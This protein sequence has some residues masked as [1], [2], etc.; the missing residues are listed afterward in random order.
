MDDRMRRIGPSDHSML[1]SIQ[2]EPS[3]ISSD[4]AATRAGSDEA[5][6]APL[7]PKCKGVGYLVADAGYDHPDF[8]RLW[9][10]G[11]RMADKL[12]LRGDKLRAMS[13][14]GPFGNKTFENFDAGIPGVARAYARA[15]KFAEQPFGW[16]IYFGDFGRGKT[17]LAAAIANRLLANHHEV[18]FAVVPDLLDHLRSTFGPTSE[19]AYDERFEQVRRA[20]ILILDDLGTENATPWAREKLFQI[21]NHRY[22]YKLPT[23]V[24]SNQKPT[25][26]DARI[27][28]RMTDRELCDEVTIIDSGDY[29]I[30]SREQRFEQKKQGH[31]QR[32]GRRE[33]GK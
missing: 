15:L 17:H 22:N 31:L 27:F 13:N 6:A 18:L 12:Q 11:C 32:F 19:I 20:S 21:V 25:A 3:A 7:C 10:C 23:V 29:R 1:R 33:T 16:L 24:T 28:S 9:P 4:E 8:G 30:V 5:P 14:L 2:T 26:I